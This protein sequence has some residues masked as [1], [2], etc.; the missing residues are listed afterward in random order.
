MYIN[1]LRNIMNDYVVATYLILKNS[2]SLTIK[3]LIIK[4]A[5]NI[6]IKT[7]TLLHDNPYI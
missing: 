7:K 2:K 6:R 3:K 4:L 5:I 1:T